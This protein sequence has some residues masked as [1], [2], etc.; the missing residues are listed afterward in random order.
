MKYEAHITVEARDGL[1]GIFQETGRLKDFKT[2]RFDIDEVDNMDGK[3]FMT[4]GR[5]NL[6]DLKLA[7]R[8]MLMALSFMNYSVVRFKIEETLLDSKDGATIDDIRL[9]Q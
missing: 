4:A 6:D 5:D 2:S 9:R 1:W 7:V 8:V 3:W